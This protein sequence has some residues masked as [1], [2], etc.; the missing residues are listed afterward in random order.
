MVKTRELE[1]LVVE[2]DV[3]GTT[4]RV[5]SGPERVKGPETLSVRVYG[6]PYPPLD[7]LVLEGLDGVRVHRRSGV[8]L[9]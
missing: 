3:V 5:V 6:G 8:M 7:R 9:F 2:F 1:V 4:E